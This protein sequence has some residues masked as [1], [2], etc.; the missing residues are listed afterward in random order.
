LL[1]LA[2]L[3]E[4]IHTIK[5]ENFR[6]TRDFPLDNGS[7]LKLFGFFFMNLF[8]GGLL[9]YLLSNLLKPLSQIGIKWLVIYSLNVLLIGW[10]IL[11]YAFP[12]G[13]NALKSF[14][15]FWVEKRRV[16]EKMKYNHQAMMLKENE[17][18]AIESKYIT[19]P[20]HEEWEKLKTLRKDLFLS[21]FHLSNLFY[22][23]KK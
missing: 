20:T 14:F 6:L 22:T 21:E 13:M 11:Q 7:F 12:K 2:Q 5:T 15:A 10:I 9:F 18:Y 8:F 1:R 3:K 17:L 23:H 4:D 19:L 16:K